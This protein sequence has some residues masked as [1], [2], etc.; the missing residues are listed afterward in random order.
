MSPG[1]KF[2]FGELESLGMHGLRDSLALA[3]QD[4]A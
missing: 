1:L 4:V 3:Y 2:F